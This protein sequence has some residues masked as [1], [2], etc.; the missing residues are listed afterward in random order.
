MEVWFCKTCISDIFPLTSLDEFEFD[1]HMHSEKPSDI[2]LLLPPI[3]VISTISDLSNLG[4]S[5]IE[6]NIPT[7]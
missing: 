7:L 1:T 3:D 2:E 5:Y 4:N 6:S